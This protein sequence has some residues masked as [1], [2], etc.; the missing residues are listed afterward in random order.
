MYEDRLALILS[1][2]NAP[3]KNT[4]FVK[5]DVRPIKGPFN[6]YVDKMRGGGQKCL[7]LSTLRV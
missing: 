2:A 1:V 3:F 7:F 5:I 6:N 4:N